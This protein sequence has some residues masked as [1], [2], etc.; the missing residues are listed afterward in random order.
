MVLT[1]QGIK[2]LGLLI[3]GKDTGNGDCHVKPVKNCR[4]II[5]ARIFPYGIIHADEVILIETICDFL[6][7]GRRLIVQSDGGTK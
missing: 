6:N 2:S 7:D 1:V 4:Y 5:E 3:T